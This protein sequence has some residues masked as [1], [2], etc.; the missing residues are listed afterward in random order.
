[1]RHFDFD[2]IAR[3]GVGEGRDIGIHFATVVNRANDV[4][5]VGAQHAALVGH[6]HL[7][8][9]FTHAVHHARGDL[10]PSAVLAHHADGADIVVAGVDFL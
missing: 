2:R 10:A 7:G 5:A 8:E 6:F 3:E 9:T 1:M 4:A